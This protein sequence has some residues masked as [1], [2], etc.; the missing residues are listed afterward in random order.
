MIEGWTNVED[1][2]PEQDG[3][4]WVKV[5]GAVNGVMKSQFKNGYFGNE[6]AEPLEMLGLKATHW[7]E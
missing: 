5:R 6:F 7:R 4:F 1:E 3:W 2:L